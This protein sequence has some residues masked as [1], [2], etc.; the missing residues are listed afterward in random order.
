MVPVLLVEKISKKDIM[1]LLKI[2][3]KQTGLLPKNYL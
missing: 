2:K 3:N 1:Q